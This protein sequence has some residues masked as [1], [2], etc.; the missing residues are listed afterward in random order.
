MLQT[1]LSFEQAALED[2]EDK[3]LCEVLTLG[4]NK[5]AVARA[6][7]LDQCR[8]FNVVRESSQKLEERGRA[9][10]MTCVDEGAI[11]RLRHDMIYVEHCTCRRWKNHA[12]K[13]GMS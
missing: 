9:L 3:I 5:V 7:E 10:Q 6:E 11:M 8:R 2:I 4:P 13:F 12:Y 1:A